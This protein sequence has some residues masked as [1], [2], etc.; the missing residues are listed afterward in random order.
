MCNVIKFDELVPATSKTVRT[1]ARYVE[2][3]AGILNKGKFDELQQALGITYHPDSSLLD[4]SIGNKRRK[5]INI[6]KQ[7]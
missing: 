5:H 7:I 6:N 4:R 3:Q 1:K 2:S